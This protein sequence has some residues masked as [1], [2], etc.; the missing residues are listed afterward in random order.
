MIGDMIQIL[1]N[2]KQE[3]NI[4]VGK[5]AAI[6]ASITQAQQLVDIARV[7]QENNNKIAALLKQAS[8]VGRSNT[9]DHLE[10]VCT[11]ALKHVLGREI[12]FIID[13]QDCRGRPEA[14]FF[15]QYTDGTELIKVKP[16]E[17]A[18]G[19]VVDVI[20]TALRFAF[21]ELLREPTIQGPIL[22]DEPCKMVSEI[23]ATRMATLLVEL[24]RT[25]DRQTIMISHSD[26]YG[27]NA[28]KEFQV[29]L[30]GVYSNVIEST[31]INITNVNVEDTNVSFND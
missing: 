4:Q 27:T 23:A 30:N 5:K 20:S 13:I 17:A 9:K 6:E 7:K 10:A 1:D 22:L 28:D 11:A 3:Y 29:M 18:G 25:F 14:E 15:I 12:E 2:M 21:L 31:Q 19:G 8:D 16:E 26:I 24:Q